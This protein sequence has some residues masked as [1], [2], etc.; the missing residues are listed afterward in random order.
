MKS[1]APNGLIFERARK[2]LFLPS[3]K[4]LSLNLEITELAEIAGTM[5]SRLQSQIPTIWLVRSCACLASGVLSQSLECI[6]KSLCGSESGLELMFYVTRCC[7]LFFLSFLPSSLG[8]SS[9][10]KTPQII[11]PCAS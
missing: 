1:N 6:F 4:L 3:S 9:D 7:V 10:R 11:E 2:T 8:Y 5:R